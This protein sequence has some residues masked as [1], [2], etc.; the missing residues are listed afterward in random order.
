MVRKRQNPAAAVS[1]VPIQPLAKRR[2]TRH[3][4]T[5]DQK[6]ALREWYF[7]DEM[8]GNGPGGEKTLKDIGIWWEKTYGYFLTS[9]SAS[10]YISDRYKFLDNSTVTWRKQYSRKRESK[11]SALEACLFEW[12]QR[13]EVAGGQCTGD[14]LRTKATEFWG[15]LAEYQGV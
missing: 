10:D 12:Q 15:K 8:V 13:F 4:P 14:V 11:W 3:N 5:N 7:D 9:S 2:R 1:G 6:Y